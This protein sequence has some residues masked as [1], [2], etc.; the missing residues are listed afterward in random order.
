MSRFP[1]VL[2]VVLALGCESQGGIDSESHFL[3]TRNSDC[4]GATCVAG[5]C[6]VTGR[7]TTNTG[8]T[9]GAVGSGG[10]S[11]VNGTGGVHGSSGTDGATNGGGTSG[12]SNLDAASSS[13]GGASSIESGT[14]TGGIGGASSN[15]G[16]TSIGG[17]GASSHD[18]G[19]SSGGADG[20]SSQDGGTS[21][22][23]SGGLAEA[24]TRRDAADAGTDAPLVAACNV[25]STTLLARSFGTNID[26]ILLDGGYVYFHDGGGISRVPRSGGSTEPLASFHS[27]AY[28]PEHAFVVD[29][30]GLTWWEPGT[31][32]DGAIITRVNHSAKTGGPV[33][34]LATLPVAGSVSFSSIGL[35]PSGS[36]FLWPGSNGTTPIP[37]L[38]V[39]PDGSV[40]SWGG[41]Y[42]YYNRSND[43]VFDG[44]DVF[45]TGDNGVYIHVS[46]SIFDGFTSI[47]G[48]NEAQ[49][50]VLDGMTMYIGS[51]DASG[52]V[53]VYSV[54]KTGGTANMLF[55]G[56]AGGIYL[57]NMAIDANYLY[58][59]EVA[60][61]AIV[62][63][64]KDGSNPTEFVKGA[65]FEHIEHVAVDDH[66]IYWSVQGSLQG[67]N[68]TPSGVYAAPK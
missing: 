56:G 3:C 22:S 51:S 65:Q 39:R 28:P 37:L 44:T 64:G 30:S 8:G 25:T 19:T 34:T 11:G 13:G 21:S 40:H 24:S 12:A 5:R 7:G 31:G 32:G 61:P 1:W 52:A 14:D 48:A 50:I 53:R 45:A 47:T 55:S 60:T 63:M 46:N 41:M 59:V 43:V 35:G 29:D 68:R 67:P 15:D 42:S 58:A 66:C 49:D 18:G 33:T 62:R 17:A 4:D 27:S 57:G 20:S 10:E 6:R 16:A 2:A 9:S 26:Q 38:Q 54:P 23:G 36:F